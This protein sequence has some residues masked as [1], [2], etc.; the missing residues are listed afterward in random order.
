MD[1]IAERYV[2]LVLALGTH[3]ADYVDAYY[4]P[5]AW[6]AEAAAQHQTLDQIRQEGTALAGSLESQ[7]PSASADELSRLRHRYLLA[8]IKSLM[9]RAAMLAGRHYSFDEESRA[10]YDAVAPPVELG[11]F[12]QTLAALDKLVPGRGSLP[13]R[14]AAWRKQFEIP[15][16]RLA[17]VFKVG[18]HFCQRQAHWL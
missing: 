13:G 12:D 8:Q 7:P 17:E 15:A 11:Q 5:P 18:W 2:K 1:S 16:P 9:A 10:L 14:Y 6:K 3:D 4:G